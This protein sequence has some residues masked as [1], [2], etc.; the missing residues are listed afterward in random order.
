MFDV[1]SNLAHFDFA[2]GWASAGS[3]RIRMYYSMV[4]LKT[5]D[6]YFALIQQRR[7]LTA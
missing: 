7:V 1:L 3:A 6:E 5:L 2:V 4:E